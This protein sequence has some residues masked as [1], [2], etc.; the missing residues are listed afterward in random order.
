VER[1]QHKK[2]DEKRRTTEKEERPIEKERKAGVF[3]QRAKEY[4]GKEI[5]TP[6]KK[7]RVNT[8]PEK[9]RFRGKGQRRGRLLDSRRRFFQNP[10]A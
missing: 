5:L 2:G 8:C 10:P 4:N 9:Q 6:F 1:S 3:L 7:K